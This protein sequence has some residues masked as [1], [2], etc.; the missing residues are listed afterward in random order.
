[1]KRTYDLKKLFHKAW[2]LYRKALKKGATTFGTALK[3]AWAWLK[4]QATNA[5]KVEAAAQA[6]GYGDMVCRTWYGW[7]AMGREVMH[8][9]KAAFQVTVDDPCTAKGTRVES[10][11]TY[12]QTFAPLAA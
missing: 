10:Y 1:M 8:T 4:V 2:S 3:A 9:E 6:A 12:E 5:E 7:K 11:F